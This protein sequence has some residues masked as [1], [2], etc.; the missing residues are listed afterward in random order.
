VKSDIHTSHIGGG[1]A[2]EF[3]H[4]LAEARAAIGAVTPR[5]T[6]L[7]R[8]VTEPSTHAVGEW[9]IGE[10]A[11]HLSHVCAG[12]LMSAST[13]GA[14]PGPAIGNTRLEGVARFNAEN[15][16]ADRERDPDVLAS[17][18]DDRV[19]ELLESTRGLR[20]DETVTWLGGMQLPVALI[21]CHFLG[22]LIV[23]G[24]DIAT[25]SQQP[26]P[27]QPED[28]ALA[29]TFLF[30]FLETIGPET[31]KSFVNAD[32][33]AGLR[34]TFELRVR[35]SRSWFVEFDDGAMSFSNALRGPVDCHI[36]ADPV[37]FLLIAFGRIGPIRPALTGRLFVWG[38]KP[39]LAFK[40]TRL[41]K[42]P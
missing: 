25:A 4:T 10:V 18:I 38:R 24:H 14:E 30:S 2:T 22:E 20:G 15:L 8:G 42:S 7:L 40:F 13:A 28:A 41:L 17:R 3:H 37:T 33:A 32:A 5:L 9:N 16:D 23:H 31:R 26:W 11:A 19:S 34:A 36:S 21:F 29:G 1:D 27:I 35:G 6:A 39:H 12:E